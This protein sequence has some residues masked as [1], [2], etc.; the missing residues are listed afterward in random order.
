M[1]HMQIKTL[2]PGNTKYI[3]S[4]DPSV[5]NNVKIYLCCGGSCFNHHHLPWRWRQQVSPKRWYLSVELHE[6]LQLS[7][8]PSRNCLISCSH[9]QPPNNFEKPRVIR[10]YSSLPVIE[11]W[12]NIIVS[13]P[14]VRFIRACNTHYVWKWVSPKVGLYILAKRIISRSID[15]FKPNLVMQP[16]TTLL[17]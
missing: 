1:W 14:C 7:L 6:K 4:W 11:L 10:L 17:I 3:S 15:Q 9:K 5:F 13:C 12:F 2:N 8:Q 16:T